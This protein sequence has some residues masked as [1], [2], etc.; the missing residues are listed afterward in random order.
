M[1]YFST[2]LRQQ[3]PTKTYF[4]F[5]GNG[6]SSVF[7]IN[8]NLN[9]NATFVVVRKAQKE[10]FVPPTVRHIS[11]N[12]AQ[13][14]FLDAVPFANEYQIGF[15]IFLDNS[16]TRPRIESTKVFN[17][18]FDGDTN[19]VFYYYGTNFGR[20]AWSNP[21]NSGNLEI[22]LSSLLANH[23]NPHL[24]CDRLP[25]SQVATQNLPSSSILIDLG[26]SRRLNCT[27]YSIRG[28]DFDGNH[29]RSWDF[30]KTIN[31]TDLFALDSQRNNLTLQVNTWYSKTN[32]LSS[33]N[34]RYFV[35]KQ[36]GLSSSNDDF[37]AIGEIEL[38]GTLTTSFLV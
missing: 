9:S 15:F 26:E 17:Y 1:P 21:Y 5:V 37:L 13:I 14:T 4:E 2:F 33:E 35:I 10:L 28:R 16:F 12:S 31:G 30:A 34:S 18:V 19:G 38:Y 29:L 27:G 22:R 23:N 11:L 8:H 3:T 25:S 24:L 32:I 20:S 6:I 7:T 36:M